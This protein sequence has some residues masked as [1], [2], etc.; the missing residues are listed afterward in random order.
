MAKV[1]V[2]PLPALNISIFYYGCRADKVHLTQVN[3][4]QTVPPLSQRAK[5][6]SDD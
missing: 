4:L 1:A 5:S 3:W 2:L 6:G